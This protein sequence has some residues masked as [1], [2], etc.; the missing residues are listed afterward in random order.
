MGD[1]SYELINKNGTERNEEKL[2]LGI[3]GMYSYKN[4]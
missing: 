2:A 4:G 1:I 3:T